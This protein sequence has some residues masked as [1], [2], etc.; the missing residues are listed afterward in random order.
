MSTEMMGVWRKPQPG[1]RTL[2]E[3]RHRLGHRPGRRSLAE[4]SA[5]DPN[6]SGVWSTRL[7]VHLYRKACSMIISLTVL[8]ILSTTMAL[9]TNAKPTFLSRQEATVIGPSLLLGLCDGY[10]LRAQIT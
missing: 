1:Q 2:A 7:D 9:L 8:M 3:A 4:T 5:A 10:R 6:R